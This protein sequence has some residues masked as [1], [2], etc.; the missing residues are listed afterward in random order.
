M[1]H[2][3][4]KHSNKVRSLIITLAVPHGSEADAL[5]RIADA[6]HRH[7]FASDE[8]TFAKRLQG[9]PLAIISGN[10]LQ[11]SGAAVHRIVLAIVG[12]VFYRR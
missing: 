1:A 4:K 3:F 12:E 5:C 6:Q 11:A 10:H 9:I 2:R 7:P 8:R